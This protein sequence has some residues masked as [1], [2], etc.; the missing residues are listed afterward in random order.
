M[1][2]RLLIAPPCQDVVFQSPGAQ[3]STL[4]RASEEQTDQQS[5][6]LRSTAPVIYR[7]IIAMHTQLARSHRDKINVAAG[8]RNLDGGEGTGAPAEVGA[9]V[10]YSRSSAHRLWPRLGGRG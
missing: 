8:A 4:P 5:R 3:P 1:N 10:V 2:S 6:I 7:S 9:W